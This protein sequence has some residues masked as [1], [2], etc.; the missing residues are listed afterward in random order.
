MTSNIRKFGDSKDLK[1]N[2]SFIIYDAF[3]VENKQ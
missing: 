1:V 2:I 3:I